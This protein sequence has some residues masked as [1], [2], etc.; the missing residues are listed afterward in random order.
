MT[1]KALRID[2]GRALDVKFAIEVREF[3]ELPV[4]SEDEICSFT[5]DGLCMDDL[6]SL[7]R[8]DKVP[9]F[10]RRIHPDREGSESQMI[11]TFLELAG[12]K[13]STAHSDHEVWEREGTSDGVE[14]VREET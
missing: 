7:G 5:I 2:F 9:E 14:V 13:C 11:R 6:C 12:C 3:L 4:K 1:P 8:M 10:Q